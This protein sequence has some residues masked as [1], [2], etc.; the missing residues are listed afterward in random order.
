MQPEAADVEWLLGPGATLRRLAG[1]W[2]QRQDYSGRL[3][4]A[5]TLTAVALMPAF[6]ALK[7]T[8]DP[9]DE[10]EELAM[11]GFVALVAGGMLVKAALFVHG[12][13]ALR[14][15]VQLL[16]WTR[17]RYGSG[18]SGDAT[19]RRYRKLS[20]RVYF[21]LQ[22]ASV[23]AISGWV[24]SPLLSR[25]VLQGAPESGDARRQ[26]PTPAWLP[27]DIQASPTYE[28]LYAMLAFCLLIASE[29]SV[30]I[31]SFFI[32]LML[33]ISAEIEVLS[34]NVS[35]MQRTLT[36]TPQHKDEDWCSNV[37]INNETQKFSR[38]QHSL[39]TTLITEDVSDE[40]IY[41]LL[42]NN[43]RHHQT[44]FRLVALLQSSMT[45]SIF[46]LLLVNMANLCSSVFVTAVLLQRDKSV[47]KALKSLVAIPPVLYQTGLYCIF[48]NIITDQSEKLVNSAFNCGWADCDIRF[49]RILLIFMMRATQP[50]EI[51][52]GKT[53]KLSKQMLVQR[54]L[55]RTETDFGVNDNWLPQ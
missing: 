39:N 38:S 50:M 53:C 3:R 21:Y 5:L 20:D 4:A 10:L 51:T 33:M 14:Q 22:A 26:L 31:D 18:G 17:G 52:V 13:R 7:L 45:V 6:V 35:A 28:L 19:R 42:V 27:L 30:G 36:E 11:C 29:T 16:Y 48:G 2:R 41:S 1:L 32:H 25:I 12:G 15:L 23:P 46:V 54:V 24:C 34:Q 44:I 40:E 8:M 55:W 9:P 47:T 43:V 49:K 37:E